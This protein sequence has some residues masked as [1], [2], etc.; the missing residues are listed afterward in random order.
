MDKNINNLP[1]EK[2]RL[3]GSERVSH[4]VK[5]DTKPHSYMY[6]AFM[7][8]CKNKGSVVAAIVII[9]MILF[10]IIVPFCTPYTVA[11]EDISFSR[12][13]PKS[14]LFE[15]TNFWDGCRNTV[16]SSQKYLYDYAIG[17][18]LKTPKRAT[19]DITLSKTTSP[20]SSKT[21]CIPTARIHI[22]KT[23]VSTSRYL[24]ISTSRYKN[25]KT[26]RATR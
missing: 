24:W 4:D 8:F 19:A 14:R 10:A 5:L 26:K 16:E 1:K 18:E 20:Q 9:I 25:I 2:F 6:D 17:I 3:V 7:R 12:A 23:A 15:N 11:Y 21:A 22:T 13:L